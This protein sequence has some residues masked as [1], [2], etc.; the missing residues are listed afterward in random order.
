[1]V[2]GTIAFMAPELHGFTHSEQENISQPRYS[3]AADIWA[4]GEISFQL[5][6]RS[7]TFANIGMLAKYTQNDLAFPFERLER[8][9]ATFMAQYFI[10]FAMNPSPMSRPT[11]DQVLQHPWISLHKQAYKHTLLIKYIPPNSC[12][13]KIANIY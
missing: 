2:G 1:M 11:S 4:L 6:T 7:S 5:L 10:L 12:F 13:S 3:C 8:V 9:K